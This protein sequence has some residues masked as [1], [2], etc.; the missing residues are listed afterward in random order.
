MSEQEEYIKQLEEENDK[1]RYLLAQRYMR[2]AR[3]I[4]WSDD[5]EASCHSEG[6][7]GNCGLYCRAFRSGN[8]PIPDEVVEE[9]VEDLNFIKDLYP[10]VYK[11]IDEQPD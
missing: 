3:Y 2:G 1:M 5:D 10:D 9:H 8:C 11:N 4:H 7:A 6:Q